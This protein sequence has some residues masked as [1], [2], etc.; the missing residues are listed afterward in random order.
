MGSDRLGSGS[1][2]AIFPPRNRLSRH[3]FGP[4]NSFRFHL[5][6]TGTAANIQSFL[7]WFPA[8]A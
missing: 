1:L 4:A 8:G 3:S 5:V 6:T 2:A 7:L